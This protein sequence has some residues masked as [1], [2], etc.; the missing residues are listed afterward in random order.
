MQKQCQP[1]EPI[2]VG[3]RYLKAK[4][5]TIEANCQ[6]GVKFSYTSLEYMKTILSVQCLTWLDSP[7]GLSLSLRYAGVTTEH[8][9]CGTVGRTRSGAHQLGLVPAHTELGTL[10]R[11]VSVCVWLCVTAV[12]LRRGIRRRPER[13]VDVADSF[14]GR[15]PL[16]GVHMYVSVFAPS[17]M[18]R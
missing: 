13:N 12:M 10:E 6:A 2:P 4:R 7:P 5:D 1:A 14:E 8:W 18:S 15:F 11:C 16:Q 9:V 3:E 17:V